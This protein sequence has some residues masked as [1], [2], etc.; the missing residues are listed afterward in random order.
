MTLAPREL[1]CREV[2]D[3]LAGYFAGELGPEEQTIFD[4]HLAECP[5]CVTYLRSYAETMR[6]A[7]D[8]YGDDQQSATVPEPLIRAIVA[9]R[10]Q[11]LPPRGSRR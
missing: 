4:E 10:E 3:F 9:A 6:L 8:A 5:E 7:K 1:T 2:S 11:R